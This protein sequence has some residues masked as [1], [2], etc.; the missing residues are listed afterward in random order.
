MEQMLYTQVDELDE[1]TVELLNEVTADINEEELDE[2][3]ALWD[4]ANLRQ[5]FQEVSL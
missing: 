3:M 5:R 1:A 4:Y 2:A